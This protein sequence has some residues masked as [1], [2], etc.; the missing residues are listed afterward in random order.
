[1]RFFSPEVCDTFDDFEPFRKVYGDYRRHLEGLRGVLPERVLELAEP[2]GMED[3]LVVRVNHDRERR[4][5][6]LVLRCGHLQ[7][8]YYNLVLTYEDAELRPEHDAALARIARSTKSQ[9]FFG[10]DLA[11]H[12]VDA[13][14][15]GRIE[16]SLIF[17]ASEWHHP[18]AGGWIWFSVRCRALRWR[19][20]PRRTRRLPPS[21]DR[22]PGGPQG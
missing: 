14:E 22:Y 11:Y 10:C 15:G 13:A 5:L 20:E 21:Q 2:S 19:R 8:G 17:H 1:V 4:V 16:H 7:M 18:S 3:A 9:S 6:R 12:E